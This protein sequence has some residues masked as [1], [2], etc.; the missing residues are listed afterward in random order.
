MVRAQ[1]GDLD[2]PLRGG[3]AEEEVVTS[4]RTGVVRACDAALVGG[5]AFVLG[6]GRT[7]EG[8]AVHP[9]VGVRLRAR[10]GD[11]VAAGAPLAVL[12]HAGRH[13]AEARALVRS[14]FRIEG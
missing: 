5:A 4:D 3:D 9:G 11:R 10:A 1:G 7:R 6:A 13:V 8:E 14:A 2:R 12:L